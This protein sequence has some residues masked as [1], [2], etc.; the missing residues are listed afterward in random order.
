MST[1]INNKSSLVN[2]SNEEFSYFSLNKRVYREL[3][4]NQTKNKIKTDDY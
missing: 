4:L 3:K 1:N 2:N